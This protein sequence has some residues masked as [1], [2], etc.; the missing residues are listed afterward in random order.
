MINQINTYHDHRQ[1]LSKFNKTTTVAALKTARFIILLDDTGGGGGGG[2]FC[3]F[4]AFVQTVK[5]YFD[6]LL[7][8]NYEIFKAV[9]KNERP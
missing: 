8:S 6:S 3:L 7:Q 4:K 5:F 2:V 1:L 9:N